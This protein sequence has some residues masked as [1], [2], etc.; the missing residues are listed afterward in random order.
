MSR[1]FLAFIQSVFPPSHSSQWE[2]CKPNS[3]SL[4]SGDGSVHE[5][6]QAHD[7][8][9]QQQLEVKGL[10]VLRFMNEQ[11]YRE[12]ETVLQTVRTALD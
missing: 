4:Q 11:V 9:R 8:D 10:R 2:A 3:P 6:Q 12:I 1:E 7:A 5:A